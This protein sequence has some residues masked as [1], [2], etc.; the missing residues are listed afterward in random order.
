MSELY[1]QALNLPV[2][3]RQELALLLLD[4]LPVREQPVELDPEYEVELERRLAEMDS[5]RAKMLTLE[6]AMARLRLPAA[7]S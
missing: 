7:S 2:E 3:S 6:E 4:S 1:S 5:G